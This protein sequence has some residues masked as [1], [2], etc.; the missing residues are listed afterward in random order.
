[1]ARKTFKTDIRIVEVRKSHSLRRLCVW[2]NN[3]PGQKPS[4]YIPPGFAGMTCEK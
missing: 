2:A 1:M 3:L 4:A